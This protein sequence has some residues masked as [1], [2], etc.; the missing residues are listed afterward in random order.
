MAEKIGE[1]FLSLTFEDSRYKQG[2]KNAEKDAKNLRNSLDQVAVA[3]VALGVASGIALNK[4]TQEI[5]KAVKASTEFEVAVKGLDSVAEHSGESIDSARKAAQSLAKDGL[6]SVADASTTLKNLLMSGFSLPEAITLMERFK[7][8][9]A[10]N[11]QGTMAFGEAIVSASVGIK[12][13]NSILVDNMGLTKNL[14]Q[15]I[16]EA[17]FAESDLMKVRDDSAVRLALYNGML[18]E[19]APFLGDAADYANT[20]AG[21]QQKLNQQIFMA[22]V[23]IGDAL[24]PALADLIDKIEPVVVAIKD[25]AQKNPDL[26]RKIVGVTVAVLGLGVGI[27]VLGSS[28]LFLDKALIPIFARV[29]QLLVALGPIG[30]IIGVIIALGAALYYAYQEFEGVREV[31]D[32]IG[33]FIVD[34]LQPALEDLWEIV[35]NKLVDAFDSLKETAKKSWEKLKDFHALAKEKLTPTMELLADIFS[36]VKDVLLEIKDAVVD[37]YKWLEPSLISGFKLVWQQIQTHLLPALKFM[38]DTLMDALIPA[39]KDLWEVVEEDLIPALED[40]W[41]EIKPVAEQLGTLLSP[42][43]K[44][45]LM[46]LGFVFLSTLASM[47][48]FV[49]VLSVV[50]KLISVQLAVGIQI[51]TALLKALGW[52]ITNIILPFW[53]YAFDQLK[54]NWDNFAKAIEVVWLNILKPIFEKIASVLGTTVI[55]AFSKLFQKGREVFVNL[56]GF[57]TGKKDE[58]DRVWE[59][60]KNG[61]STVIAKFMEIK[62]RVTQ[63]LSGLFNL[64]TKP[65]KEA[66][67]WLTENLDKIHRALRFL[68]PSTK[69]SPSTVEITAKGIE[70]MKALYRGLYANLNSVAMNTHGLLGGSA[71][72]V[73]QSTANNSSVVNITLSPKFETVVPPSRTQLQNAAQDLID[74]AN[75]IMRRNGQPEIGNGYIKGVEHG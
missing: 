43:V 11:R 61:I 5:K 51:V 56:V 57:I 33:K 66:F 30:W 3:M 16:K 21:K 70:Q 2:I 26:V 37:V 28:L 8:I 67:D 38:K 69:G 13:G 50:I 32:K 44:Q 10:Y 1:V 72:L 39:L 20:F 71:N 64:I 40:L 15:I 49:T 46:V 9:A 22:R 73:S 12:N 24:K 75:D 17:G 63:A 47:A 27:G 53:T 58:L 62:S 42:A 52:Y 35:K 59:K 25:W 74:A 31:V 14:S 6:M 68:S 29:G 41:E 55:P 36:S 48:G 45:A 23:A 54:K 18:A 34:T 65:F 19:T 4:F 60:I 7:D